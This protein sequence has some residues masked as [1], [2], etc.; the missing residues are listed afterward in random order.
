MKSKK[1]I[2]RDF[3]R[4]AARKFETRALPDLIEQRNNLVEEMENIIK[5]AEKETRALTDDE[6]SRFDEIKKEIDGIDRQEVCQVLNLAEQKKRIWNNVRRM[7]Q[8]LKSS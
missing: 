7:R 1:Q 5:D 6:T 8:N 2:F 3:E 4:K